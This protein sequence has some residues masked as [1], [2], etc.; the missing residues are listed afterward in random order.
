VGDALRVSQAIQ[1]ITANRA[2]PRAPIG[3][4]AVPF[5]G[6]VGRRLIEQAGLSWIDLSGNASIDAPGIRIR[7]LGKPNRFAKGRRPSSLFATRN[8]RVVRVFLLDPTRRL[9]QQEIVALSGLD[10]GRVSRIVRQLVDEGHLA[11]EGRAL[12]CLRPGDLLEAWREAYDF[13]RH[14]VVRGILGGRNSD[15]VLAAIAGVLRKQKVE[16]SMTGLAGAW[17]LTGH[18]M[19]RTITLFVRGNAPDVL[20]RELGL[21]DE[22][23]GANVW[24]VAPNDDGVFMGARTQDGLRCAHPLQVY[25]DLKAHPERAAEA[26]DEVRRR[27][28][29]WATS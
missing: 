7:L 3:V 24:I 12:R 22:P 17:L 9:T 10:K 28:L 13:K 23:R 2:Q 8:S 6:E 14:R 15:E 11:R 25:L 20:S 21:I 4:L 1:Q 26:A 19:F 29:P 27:H 5:M 16:Y 18:A